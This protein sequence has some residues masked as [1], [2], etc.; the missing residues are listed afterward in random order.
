MGSYDGLETSAR[1]LPVVGSIATTAP[2]WS[3]RASYAACWAAGSI[4]SSTDA[5]WGFLPVMRPWRRSIHSVLA[6]PLRNSFSVRSIS[7]VPLTIEKNP[8]TW[9]YRGPFV[10]ERW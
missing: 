3:P 4:V 1:I 10:Y 5:P 7:L 6:W 2:R 9:P 8:V